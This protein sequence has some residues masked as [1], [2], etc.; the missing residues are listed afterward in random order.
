MIGA[1]LSTSLDAMLDFPYTSDRMGFGCL[2]QE[3]ILNIRGQL[4]DVIL[5]KHLGFLENL[6]EKSDSGWV[7]GGSEP[8]I[9]DF[10]LVPR[11]EWLATP[12]LHDGISDNLLTSF[13]LILKL[14]E[15]FNSLPQNVA[16]YQSRK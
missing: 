14:I 3:T 16:Y 10:C 15:K 4:N 11:L 13:P 9:A 5:P 6:L 7:A 2:D 8:S 12:G 1:V